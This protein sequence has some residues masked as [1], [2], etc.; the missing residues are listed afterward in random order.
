MAFNFL[1]RK[2]DAPPDVGKEEEYEEEKKKGK[3]NKKKEEDYDKDENV[4]IDSD[5]EDEEVK[6]NRE[7]SKKIAKKPDSNNSDD[8]NNFEFQKINAKLEV[9]N[10]LI[11]GFNERF[12]SVNQQIGEIRGMVLSNE[13]SIS[14]L[15]QDALKAID[16]V[17]EV[18]PDKLRIDYQ[19]IN[20][21]VDTLSEK[22]EANRQIEET[23]MNEIKD[24]RQKAG[25]FVG[26]DALLKLN[27]EV[28]KDLIELQRVG[29]RV[30]VNADKSEQIFVE[31]KKG[32]A[33][34]EKVGSM[35]SNLDSSYAGLQKEIE[36]L[37]V[38]YSNIVEADDFEDFKKTI[39]SKFSLMDNAV[40]EF[41]KLKDNNEKMMQL[42]EKTLL[43]SKKNHE[44]IEDIAMTIG[45]DKIKRVSEY[46]DELNS[47]LK[48]IDSL[49]GQISMIKKKIGIEEKKIPVSHDGQKIINRDTIKM[50][51]IEVHPKILK[52]LIERKIN[53][54]ESVEKANKEIEKKSAEKM[55]DFKEVE[56]IKK[57][58]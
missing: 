18:K 34:N 50:K 43:I 16:V 5:D 40:V 27:E 17:K 48:I 23:I 25:I 53:T 22:L 52:P 56:K 11:K 37:K 2:E 38:D 41:D 33:Q 39:N 51:N 15:N 58:I 14:R 45:D 3:K 28:K 35:V 4:N 29:S 1:K 57:E 12:G 49:A 55:K 44:D 8:F 21:K 31:L 7:I 19:K 36:K 42:I 6:E 24:L 32:F 9:V 54:L 46:E 13:K 30:R 10:A 47:I 26:T 20:L